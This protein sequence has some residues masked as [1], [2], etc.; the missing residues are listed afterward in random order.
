MTLLQIPLLGIRRRFSEKEK[1]GIVAGVFVVFGLGFASI[2]PEA[3][4]GDT[5]LKLTIARLTPEVPVIN[6]VTFVSIPFGFYLAAIWLLFVDQIKRIQSLLF[7]LSTLVA[8]VG[9]LLSG[10]LIERGGPFDIV[11]LLASFYFGRKYLGGDQL[12]R[13][14]RSDDDNSLYQSTKY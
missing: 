1:L 7:L 3:Y 9:I 13:V 2:I 6:L 5:P 4:V 8:T 10:L 14:E 12:K 11:V